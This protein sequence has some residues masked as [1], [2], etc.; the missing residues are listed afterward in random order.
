MDAFVLKCDVYFRR[1]CVIPN[2]GPCLYMGPT[3]EVGVSSRSLLFA[4][5]Y[6]GSGATLA[7]H[8]LLHYLRQSATL[9]KADF[10]F[11]VDPQNSAL[12]VPTPTP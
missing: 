5:D 6:N 2:Q 8:I 11:C 10:S 1:T 7:L 4:L 12:G 9:P 3:V